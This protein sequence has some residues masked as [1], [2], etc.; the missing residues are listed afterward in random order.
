MFVN[1][2]IRI[3]N[4]EKNNFF[5]EICNYPLISLKDFEKNNSYECCNECYL[6]YAESRKKIWKKGWRPN[7]TKIK[8]HIKLRKQMYDKIINI[9]E[10]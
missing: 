9:A 4:Y 2:N 8:E 6:T 1:D 3:I 10:D 5:C 7:K